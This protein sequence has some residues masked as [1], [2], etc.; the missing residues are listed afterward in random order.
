[1]AAMARRVVVTGLGA[2][3]PLGLD[4]ATTWAALLAGRAGVARLESF[5]VA[6]FDG[7]A[8][9]LVRGF[10]P[11]QHMEAEVVRKGER[12]VHL[13]V[14][15]A[16]AAMADANLAPADLDPSHAGAIVGCGRGG[17]AAVERAAAAY[18]RRGGRGV[19]P[20]FSVHTLP[21]M[22]AAAIAR[23]HHFHGPCFGVATACASGSHAI[24]EAAH[25][26]GRGEA[27]V[28]ITG[29]V[30]AVVTPILLAGFARAGVLAPAGDDPGSACRPFDRRRAGF[31]LGE[32]ACC[33]VLEA[34]DHARARGARS[35]GRVAGSGMGCD[36]H[37]PTTPDPTGRTL[38]RT[39]TTALHAADLAPAD[40]DYLSAHGTGTRLNDPAEAAA[41]HLALGPVAHTTPIS[42]IKGATGHLL[43]ASGALEAAVCL[44]VLRDSLA[45]ATRNLEEP[46]PACR[47]AHITG[48]PRPGSY[49]ACLSLSAGFG[50]LN[51][52]LVFSRD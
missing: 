35:Y 47:L 20:H 23:A 3:T 4:L 25:C 52:A 31:C 44:L 17:V 26:I 7:L 12:F 49:R 29:G 39:I 5:A 34:E 28:V 6:G 46:D 42:S 11:E 50:G 43:G 51:A 21:S 15:A 2:V 45:P 8:V 32:G 36:A 33:L 37:H 16:A 9:A 18:S 48:A 38:A 22:A 10:R 13:A 19:S 14:A 24:A 30:E 1:M 27:E 40:L 41:I